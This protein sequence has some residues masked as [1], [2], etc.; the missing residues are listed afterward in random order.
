MDRNADDRAMWAYN[1][2]ADMDAGRMAELRAQDQELD[3]RIAALEAKGVKA[4]PNYQPAGVDK[5]LVYKT[6]DDVNQDKKYEEDN[7]GMSAGQVEQL[8]G[9]IIGGVILSILFVWLVIWLVFI[10]EW[11]V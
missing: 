11:D 9:R 1:H 4:D 5:D 8:V 7:A 3:R 2:R 6:D 10:K